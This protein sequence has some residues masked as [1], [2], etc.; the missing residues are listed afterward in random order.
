MVRSANSVYACVCMRVCTPP[1][2]PL[3]LVVDVHGLR[4]RVALT[5]VP[6]QSLLRSDTVCMSLD[7]MPSNYRTTEADGDYSGSCDDPVP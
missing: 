3:F 2:L 6:I 7:A 4:T 5:A 1:D